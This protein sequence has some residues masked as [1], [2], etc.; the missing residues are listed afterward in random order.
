MY[1]RF[2]EISALASSLFKIRFN[3]STVLRHSILFVPDLIEKKNI[4]A[5]FWTT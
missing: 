5:G 2:I 4:L 1:S 3:F